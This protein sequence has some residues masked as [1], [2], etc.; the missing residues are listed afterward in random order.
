MKTTMRSERARNGGMRKKSPSTENTFAMAMT[1]GAGRGGVHAW[2]EAPKCR[3]A[4]LEKKREREIDTFNDKQSQT[5]E[6]K[7]GD[8]RGPGDHRK[9]EGGRP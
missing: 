6:R 3:F 4:S 5:A 2:H 1:S 8:G 9:G 7:T